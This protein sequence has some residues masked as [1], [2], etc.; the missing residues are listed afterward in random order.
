MHIDLAT[1]KG[2]WVASETL[3]HAEIS[4][5][6][7]TQHHHLESGGLQ[8]TSDP[9]LY[10]EIISTTFHM[11]R[12][13]AHQPVLLGRAAD[14]DNNNNNNDNNNIHSSTVNIMESVDFG[15]SND[16]RL[17]ED[18]LMLAAAASCGKIITHILDGYSWGLITRIS[19]VRTRTRS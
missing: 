15:D 14:N 13:K 5:K 2:A 10:S 17:V 3:G 7:A 18:S 11:N 1:L 4:P 9:N 16:H 8:E 19:T 12:R 6:S